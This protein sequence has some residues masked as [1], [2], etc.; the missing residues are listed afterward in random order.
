[1]NQN[2][3]LSACCLQPPPKQGLFLFRFD[4]VEPLCTGDN[5]LL[6]L[7]ERKYNYGA[8]TGRRKGST[9]RKRNNYI[10]T[11]NPC[12]ERRLGNLR[13]E[14]KNRSFQFHNSGIYKC[15]SIMGQNC[16]Q[17]KPLKRGCLSPRSGAPQSSMKPPWASEHLPFLLRRAVSPSLP[18]SRHCARRAEGANPTLPQ[19]CLPIYWS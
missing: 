8:F 11:D 10:Q 9:Y 16:L 2:P 19:K 1:M 4:K 15:V 18:H 7:V 5:L 14:G 13:E 6:T 3:Q 12:E 17:M